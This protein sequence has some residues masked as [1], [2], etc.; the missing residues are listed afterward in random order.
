MLV[1]AE[2]S[3]GLQVCLDGLQLVLASAYSNPRVRLLDNYYDDIKHTSLAEVGEGLVV[4]GE[5]TH[6]GSVLGG[7][8]GN[9][10][11][12]SE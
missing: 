1:V 2:E 4:D 6:G 7:H 9:G 8:V 5:E 10:G 12:V 11:S 3:A